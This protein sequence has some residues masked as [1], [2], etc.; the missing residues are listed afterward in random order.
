MSI[1]KE[2]LYLFTSLFSQFVNTKYIMRNEK[3]PDFNHRSMND[4]KIGS[5]EIRLLK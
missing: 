3:D 4:L 1:L 2:L 5:N